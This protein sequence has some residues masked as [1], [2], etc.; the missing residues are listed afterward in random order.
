[1]SIPLF[2]VYA[3]FRKIHKHYGM[4]KH[5]MDCSVDVAEQFLD[6]VVSANYNTRGRL[7]HTNKPLSVQAMIG[8]CLQTC[9]G[10]TEEKPWA[11]NLWTAHTQA[12]KTRNVSNASQLTAVRGII[13]KVILQS[14]QA[15]HI[16][17]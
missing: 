7:S 6:I 14:K 11:Y 16:Q 3:L 4:K 9:S 12:W 1:M 5:S 17:M 8:D 13:G 15:N 2:E 10:N